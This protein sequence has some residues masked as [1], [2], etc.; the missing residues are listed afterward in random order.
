MTTNFKFG[1]SDFDDVFIQRSYTTLETP[2][3]PGTLSTFGNNY[4]YQ[5]GT[6][7]EDTYVS[8]YTPPDP[9]NWKVAY[10][11]WSKEYSVTGTRYSLYIKS[12][13]SLWSVGRNQYGQ[14]GL[15]DIN[16]RTTKTQV[17]TLTDWKQV[18]G[19]DHVAAIKTDGTLW[20][21]GHNSL[22]SL[23]LGDTT[24]RSSPTQVGSL[25]DWK[26]VSIGRFTGY[27]VK[28]DGT[29]WHIATSSPTQVG[30]LTNWK[31]IST[32]GYVHAGIKT[33]GTL[34]TWG[35]NQY[36]VLGLNEP[37]NQNRTSPTQVGTLTDWKHIS[38]SGQVA[39][40]IKTDGTLWTWGAG[41]RGTLGLN[42]GLSRSSP[43]QV[44]TLTDWKYV[45][46]GFEQVKAIKTDGTLWAW[47]RFDTSIYVHSS[48][49]Q[50][51][52]TSTGWKVISAGAYMA[53]G[54]KV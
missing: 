45:D 15:G 42:D 29:L 49:P 4:S 26:Q 18:S 20:A 24:N 28:T 5:N 25:T 22:G 36:Y 34:W 32:S 51:V 10:A 38:V 11:G 2:T 13:N 7:N 52:G 43:V 44:G 21:W 53:I 17:G 33:D 1:S 46:C 48:S 50:Q 35:S 19:M 54:I 16:P 37:N 27:A 31:L 40:A 8:E 39:A 9:Y 14:L 12:D 3:V 23:G 6:L 47:G 41:S 30:T